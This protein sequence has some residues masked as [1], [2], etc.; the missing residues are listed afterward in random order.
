MNLK[1]AKATLA[2]KHMTIRSTVPGEYRVNHVGS[3]EETAYYTNDIED[4]VKTGLLM[5]ANS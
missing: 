5:A 1:T 4:A 3:G 2:D